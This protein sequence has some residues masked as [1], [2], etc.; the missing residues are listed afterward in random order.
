MRDALASAGWRAAEA[1][2]SN[3][4]VHWSDFGRM[5]WDD[6]LAGRLAGS[7]FYL[8]T[9]L[10]RKSDLHF[11]CSRRRR[12]GG[13]STADV[14]PL[15]LCADVEDEEDVDEFMTKWAAACDSS[16]V[17]LWIL[18]PS[19]ANRG[20]GIAVLKGRDVAAARQAIA[21]WPQ[22]TTW[23]MQQYVLPPMLLPPPLAAREERCGALPTTRHKFHL[24][25]HAL[26]LGALSVWVH[27]APLVLLASQPWRD[28]EG[29]VGGAGAAPPEAMLAHLTN[30]AQQQRRV[31]AGSASAS[32]G[33]AVGDRGCGGRSG[34]A[35]I[36]AGGSFCASDWICSLSEAIEA[37]GLRC[38][39][40]QQVHSHVREVFSAFANGNA[41]FLPLPHCYELFGVDFLVDAQ[42]KLWLLEVNSGPSLALFGTRQRETGLEMMRD[43]CALVEQFVL[44]TAAAL[45]AAAGDGIA[46]ADSDGAAAIAADGVQREATAAQE[47]A[48]EGQVVG[49]FECVLARPCEDAAAELAR[50]KRVVGLAGSFARSMHECVGAPV[51]GVQGLA[52]CQRE[53]ETRASHG[54]R[55]DAGP[56]PGAAA[57][58]ETPEPPGETESG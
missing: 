17:G 24:R 26:A 2:A 13:G 27:A 23:L 43:V 7:A 36:V 12:P 28:G 57:A 6:I 55:T 8:K 49:G 20:E 51:R 16:G 25:V 42:G 21:A 10:V 52:Q 5:R 46:G 44:P 18:K 31:P 35:G 34:D 50:F 30:H 11:Y 54:G 9:G 32:V 47:A 58:A 29:D 3:A 4:E 45:R 38:E 19:L 33:D 48:R 14:L 37:E 39:L 40:A 22:H 41:A 53:S 56:A 1:D 15:T